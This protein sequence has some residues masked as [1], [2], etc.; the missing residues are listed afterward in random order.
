MLRFIF[1]FVCWLVVSSASA[2]RLSPLAAAP[3][4]GRLERFQRTVTRGDF[5]R[6]LDAVYAPRGAWKGM[7]EVG[8]EAAIIHTKLS[9]PETMTLHFAPSAKSARPV[10]RSWRPAATLRRAPKGR[11]L[12]GVSVV[13]DPGHIG[14]DWAVM[15]ER[16]FSRPG[17]KPVQEGD[18]TLLV[19]KHVASGLRALG[20]DVSLTRSRAVP[21]SRFTVDALRPPARKEL[22]LLGNAEPRENYAGPRDPAKGGTVQAEA[23]RLFYRVAEIRERARLVNKRLVPDMVVCIH[24]NADAWGAPDAPVFT[25]RNDLHTL[26]HGCYAADELRFDDQRFEMLLKLLSR[27]HAEEAAAAAPV[28][29]ALAKATG[30]PPYVYTT[31]N[32]VRA[33]EGEFVWARNLLANRLF[34]CPVIF[35]EPY[36]MNNEE[37]CA[38]VQAGDYEGEREVAGKPRPSIYREYAGAVV[39]GLRAYYAGARRK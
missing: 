29:A 3:D 22:A 11:P 20:A 9:P 18:M 28:S 19:A 2:Q 37:V 30:L 26:I 38:R 32:A 15:E 4:W 36:R 39:E 1:A 21:A 13:L 34:A 17:E 10:P 23:E 7:I 27:T 16:S 8:E 35:L 24:F 12:A 5:E 6:L 14:G 33:G 25:P 31:P